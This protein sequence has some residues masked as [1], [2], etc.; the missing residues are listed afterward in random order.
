MEELK[1][2][3]ET[4]A[5]LPTMTLWVLG[6][7]LVYKLS[8]LA[9]LYG[10][11]RFLAEKFVEWKTAPPAPPPP[12]EFNLNGITINE[13]VASLLIAQLIRLAKTGYIHASD[14][15]DLAVAIDTMVETRK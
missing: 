8:I 4:V 11:V 1:L 6:G 14:V 2:L 7:Y 10:T 3:I 9:S 12:K 5:G 13:N 15:K